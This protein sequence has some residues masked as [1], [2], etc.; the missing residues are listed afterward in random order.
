MHRWT[1]DDDLAA[2][3]VYRFQ[4]NGLPYTVE[5]IAK[6]RGIDFGSFKMRVANFKAIDGKGNLNHAA[7][8]SVS[9]FRRYGRLTQEELRAKAFPE[10]PNH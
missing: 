4:T 7:K 10:L 5:M 8:Q 9:V 2:L 1:E 3:Y 6:R